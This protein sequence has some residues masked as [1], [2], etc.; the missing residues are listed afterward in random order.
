M[1]EE[2]FDE[3]GLNKNTMRKISLKMYITNAVQFW[4]VIKDII[5]N[6]FI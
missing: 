4:D 5:F 2:I 1:E 6:V 3:V